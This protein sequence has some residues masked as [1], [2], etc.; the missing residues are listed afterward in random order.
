MLSP[1]VLDYIDDDSTVWKQEPLIS[2]VDNKQLMACEQHGFWQSMDT[3]RDKTYLEELWD[4][5]AAP[6]KV[7]S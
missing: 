5:A 2:L 1:K 7:W 6:W 4:N 3:L